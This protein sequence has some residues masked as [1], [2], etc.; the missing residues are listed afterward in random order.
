MNDYLW[1]LVLLLGYI[2]LSLLGR[3]KKRK[4]PARQ[5]APR[6]ME[7]ALQDLLGYATPAPSPR[8]E[9]LAI[10]DV[11]FLPEDPASE[12]AV[13]QDP[14]VP[15]PPVSRTLQGSAPPAPNPWSKKLRAPHSARDAFVLSVIFGAPRAMRPPT[16]HPRA[17]H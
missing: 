15:E 7:A 12:S 8:P 9:H 1:T 13:L 3:K 11:P 16:Y 6:S 4:A 5:P 2:I 10:Q 14:A 17:G